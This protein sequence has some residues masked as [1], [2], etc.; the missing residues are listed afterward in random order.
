MVPKDPSNCNNQTFGLCPQCA[1]DHAHTM[2]ALP[3]EHLATCSS[4]DVPNITQVF[5]FVS[6]D[7]LIY[8]LSMFTESDTRF[9]F[10][11]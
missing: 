5:W 6:T 11:T 9:R 1:Q 7:N 2:A 8:L 4:L 10:Y 3:F